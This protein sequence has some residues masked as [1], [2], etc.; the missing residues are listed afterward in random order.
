MNPVNLTLT[1]HSN[2]LIIKI[3]TCLAAL[4]HKPTP[5][6]ADIC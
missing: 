6:L 4:P 1:Q 2:L 5:V 3:Q